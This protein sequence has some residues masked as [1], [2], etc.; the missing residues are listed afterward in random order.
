MS[1]KARVAPPLLG[2]LLLAAACAGDRPPGAP[3]VAES[4]PSPASQP[5]PA[6]VVTPRIA[7]PSAYA[8][9]VPTYGGILVLANRGD[10]P[11]AFD[12]MRTSSIALHHVAGGLFGP[13]NL[14]TR[15]GTRCER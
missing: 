4:G 3:R 2:L 11:A 1:I 13:G 5:E 10:P 7:N 9:G 15:C 12:P 6:A 14:V 8:G